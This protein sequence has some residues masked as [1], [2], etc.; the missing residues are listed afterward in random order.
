M[1]PFVF[2]KLSDKCEYQLRTIAKFNLSILDLKGRLVVLCDMTKC[3]AV[4]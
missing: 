2:G 3:N 4:F 1:I